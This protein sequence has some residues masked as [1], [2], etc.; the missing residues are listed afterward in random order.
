MSDSDI[1]FHKI[2]KCYYS[3]EKRKYDRT[4]WSAEPRGF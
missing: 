1:I 4:C 2:D 3:R